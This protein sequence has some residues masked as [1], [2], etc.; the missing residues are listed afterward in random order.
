MAIT[1]PKKGGSTPPTSTANNAPAASQQAAPAPARPAQQQAQ[2]APSFGGR[3]LPP[4]PPEVDTSRRSG[5]FEKRDDEYWAAH[6]LEPGEHTFRVCYV[7]KIIAWA[8]G[9]VDVFCKVSDWNAFDNQPNE[10]HGRPLRW[11]QQPHPRVIDEMYSSDPE[12]SA[13]GR[14]KYGYWRGDI[15]RTYTGLGLPDT[16]WAQDADGN[17]EVPWPFFFVRQ[18][19]TLHVPICFSLTVVATVPTKTRGSFVNIVDG[20]Q[21]TDAK[22]G[23][24]QAPL[25]Y[26][27]P[28][29]L[30]EQHRWGIADR[31][32]IGRP[33][34]GP[35]TEIAVLDRNTVPVPHAGLTTWKDL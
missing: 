5:N 21:L 2:R 35:Q 4:A 28:P 15:V 33:E 19:G 24:V 27:V 11:S 3:G 20:A 22:A 23:W 8:G 30:A 7:N 16:A 1:L 32:W 13:A 25:P 29:I 14:K 10:H 26:E 6:P 17:V 9:G 12:V 34:K 31:K 18:V